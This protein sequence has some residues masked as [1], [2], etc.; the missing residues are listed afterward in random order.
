VP[1]LTPSALT[2]LCEALTDGKTGCK[3][4]GL[5]WIDIDL[6]RGTIEARGGGTLGIFFVEHLSGPLAHIW[7]TRAPAWAQPVLDGRPVEMPDTRQEAPADDRQPGL[8]ELP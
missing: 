6:Q 5:D 1:D 7:R 4:P 3:A 8:W 2:T